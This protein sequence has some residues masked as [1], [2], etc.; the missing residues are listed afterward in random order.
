[1]AIWY[2]DNIAGNNA[3]DGTTPADA[4]KTIKYLLENEPV[5]NGDEIRVAGSGWS[6]V[7][8]GTV[9]PTTF[10]GTILTTST[11]LTSQLAIGTLISFKDPYM[12]DRKIIYAIRAITA[13]TITLNS[14]QYYEPGVQYEIEKVTTNY[15]SATSTGTT[16]ENLSLVNF[17]DLKIEGGWVDNFTAQ[18][19]ITAMVLAANT[20]FATAGIRWGSTV[21]NNNP[22]LN[23]FC[24]AN[25]STSNAYNFS[26]TASA[27]PRIY[28]G[29]IWFSNA[30]SA[31]S[32]YQNIPGKECNIHTTSGFTGSNTATNESNLKWNI[33][34]YYN[35]AVFSFNSTRQPV[36]IDNWWQRSGSTGNTS[37]NTGLISAGM[38][39]IN[40]F[41][42]VWRTTSAIQAQAMFA[43]DA[44]Y[45]VKN[46][47]QH[48]DLTNKTLSLGT[49]NANQN[50][51]FIN[52][53]LNVES[54]GFGILALIPGIAITQQRCMAR[55]IEGDKVFWQNAYWL[56]ADSSVYDTGT[57][58]LRIRTINQVG[59]PYA[60]L[61]SVY[62]PEGSTGAKTVTI[63]LKSTNPVAFEYGLGYN[64]ASL[65][66]S[67]INMFQSIGSGTTTTSWADYPFTITSSQVEQF[68]GSYIVIA[69]QSANPTPEHIWIDSVTIS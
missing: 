18:T 8:G 54:F 33:D 20:G 10:G 38:A 11:D 22:S 35:G 61:K 43:S 62:I 9:T 66:A 28:L 37:F 25:I 63:R 13:T 1:M 56:Y 41:N 51:Q 39:T 6:A 59:E 48:G 36:S 4:V 40:N 53:S 21:T 31:A 49:N 68:A 67:N 44:Y 50:I 27:V 65:D 12:G 14:N 34:N 5:A 57:N 2:T 19:G 7:T 23:N 52:E 69:L 15:Y 42:I 55:D 64:G 24:F 45:I 3:N 17:S 60:P 29:N 58:S 46:V 32:S 30:S 26:N 47:I 16:F